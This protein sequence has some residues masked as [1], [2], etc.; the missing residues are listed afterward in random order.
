[1]NGTIRRHR[2]KAMGV[3]QVTETGEL[4][5][6]YISQ[7]A[8]ALATNISKNLINFAVNGRRLHA[9][10][11]RWVAF[12][13]PEKTKRKREVISKM[14]LREIEEYMAHVNRDEIIKDRTC[15]MCGRFFVSKTPRNRRCLKCDGVAD[16]YGQEHLYSAHNCGVV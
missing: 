4:V 2:N 8:A 13:L 6:T 14:E 7:K 16:Q 1:M 5:A 11:Y 9:G 10:G 3:K 15:L 12:E